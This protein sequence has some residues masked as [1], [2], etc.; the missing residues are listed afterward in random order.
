MPAPAGDQ[1]QDDGPEVV[2][3]CGG[4]GGARMAAGLAAALPEPGRLAV[5]VNT[6]DDDEFYGLHVSP[7]VDTVLYTL[8]GWANPQTGWGI[9]G[10]TGGFLSAME[11]LGEPSWFFLGDRDLAIHVLRTWWLRSGL[12]LTQVTSRLGQRLGVRPRVL[13]MS[14]D[15]V[16]TRVRVRLE[17]QEREL[18][19]QEYFVRYRAR[20]PVVGVRFEGLERARPAPGVLQAL[21]GARVV[22]IAPSNP[23]VSVGP[24]LGLPGV[25]EAMAA[26]RRR[27]AVSPLVA[28]RAFKGPAATMMAGL[29]LR[30]DAAGVA[31]L[32]RGLVDVFVLDPADEGLVP[33]IEAMGIRTVVTPIAMPDE[34]A[35]RSLALSV[36]EAA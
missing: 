21:S 13:P 31:E 12:T 28:G 2:V 18:A 14:D 35:R 34:P 23:L 15:P 27:I 20:P 33:L 24:I 9:A 25:R 22:V 6:A 36:L 29:G 30:A 3:L 5:V 4:V 11:R 8:A 26:R 32:Y 16:R 1:G 17:G 7:D 19:F 10:D